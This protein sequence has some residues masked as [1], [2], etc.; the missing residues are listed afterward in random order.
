MS[1][2]EVATEVPESKRRKVD[3]AHLNM[4]CLE[5]I[6]RYLDYVALVKLSRTCRTWNSVAGY[7]L[8]RQR[9]MV[10]MDLFV[11]WKK[12][13]SLSDKHFV[14]IFKGKSE[15]SELDISV[16][17]D[18][19]KRSSKFLPQGLLKAVME[20]C[21]NITKLYAR[22]VIWD[23][24]PALSFFAGLPHLTHLYLDYSSL[25]DPILD[26]ILANC[27][28][29]VD[30]D[31]SW[32]KCITRHC[33]EMHTANNLKSLKAGYCAEL[34]DESFEMYELLDL[35]N[36]LCPNL[37]TLDISGYGETGEYFEDI[38][39]RDFECSHGYAMSSLKMLS[40]K[41]TTGFFE[42]D[43]EMDGPVVTRTPNVETL[44][45]NGS[46]L[47]FE[48]LNKL[49]EYCPKLTSLDMS[50][51]EIK[52]QLLTSPD[53]NSFDWIISSLKNLEVLRF[54]NIY[55]EEDGH[56]DEGV[57]RY[58]RRFDL[59]FCVQSI[60]TH[61]KQLKVLEMSDYSDLTKEDVLRLILH[62]PQLN[63]LNIQWCLDID[64]HLISLL[65]ISSNAA[66]PGLIN[67]RQKLDILVFGTSIVK[68]VT[69]PDNIPI[70]LH[71]KQKKRTYWVNN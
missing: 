51:C 16:P 60:S 11:P 19:E 1:H 52:S 47:S 30:L 24:K 23:L 20:H 48:F 56:K 63:E 32:T 43:E 53:E 18:S 66:H 62:L 22:D 39:R 58:L 8:Q 49:S 21:P 2:D 12:I 37:E 34:I 15:L 14:V 38:F 27:N 40:L 28:S 71:F 5:M 44:D 67:R 31:V 70:E 57:P 65:Q 25:T 13:Y 68:G 6:F 64:N 3:Q 7:V 46:T 55:D 10:L 69:V 4:D 29:L 36:K 61:L 42:D 17:Y 54:G 33:F 59:R 26:V 50:G 35:I 45:L 9:K 41:S